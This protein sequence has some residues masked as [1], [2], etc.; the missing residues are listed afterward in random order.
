[1]VV[2]V[3]DREIWTGRAYGSYILKC[4]AQ[5]LMYDAL[6]LVNTFVCLILMIKECVGQVT[7]IHCF[8]YRK[9]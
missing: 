6:T 5:V 2:D 7:T 4:E 1:M 3:P 9:R 8:L